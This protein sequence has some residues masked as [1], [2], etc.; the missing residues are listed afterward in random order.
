MVEVMPCGS[1]HL[2]DA[3]SLLLGMLSEGCSFLWGSVPPDGLAPC[4]LGLLPG[5]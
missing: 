4:G 5:V 3:I 2:H 1:L